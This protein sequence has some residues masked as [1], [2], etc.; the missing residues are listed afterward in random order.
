VPRADRFAQR[1]DAARS[2]VLRVVLLDRA[3]RRF[4]YVIRRGEVGFARTEVGEVDAAGLELVSLHDD[5]GCR[6]DLDAI[7]AFG[8]MHGFSY[9]FG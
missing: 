2:R 8:E 3:H 7:D 5:G 4:L 1:H 9:F 6:R